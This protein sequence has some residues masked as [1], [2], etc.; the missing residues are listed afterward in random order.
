[1]PVS[2]RSQGLNPDG[3]QAEPP[4]TTP[5]SELITEVV[6]S[7][8]S[9]M[10]VTRIAPH[11]PCQSQQPI[12]QS[13][14]QYF[15]QIDPVFTNPTEDRT[16]SYNGEPN[17]LQAIQCVIND[18]C[19]ISRIVAPLSVP[20]AM[21]GQRDIEHDLRCIVRAI[22]MVVV[23]F[24]L[25]ANCPC[26]PIF[27]L[28]EELLRLFLV[29][30]KVTAPQELLGIF[31]NEL[32][33]GQALRCLVQIAAEKMRMGSPEFKLGII[34]RVQDELAYHVQSDLTAAEDIITTIWIFLEKTNAEHITEV[35][36][37]VRPDHIERI[38]RF[39]PPCIPQHWIYPFYDPG[40][41]SCKSEQMPGRPSQNFSPSQPPSL[42]G[43]RERDESDGTEE[44]GR[45][46]LR[47]GPLVDVTDDL[48]CTF[49]ADDVLN[50]PG[51]DYLCDNNLLRVALHYTN[52]DILNRMASTNNAFANDEFE[53]SSYTSPAPI[54]SRLDEAI[55]KLAMRHGLQNVKISDE[56]LLLRAVFNSARCANGLQ[57][58]PESPINSFSC[59]VLEIHCA[60]T[61]A[62]MEEIYS[63][64]RR[65]WGYNG[66][67]DSVYSDNTSP[68]R[69]TEEG[70]SSSSSS[71]HSHSDS[72]HT[73]YG[74]SNSFNSNHFAP[75]HTPSHSSNMS[76]SGSNPHARRFRHSHG[77]TNS[78]YQQQSPTYAPGTSPRPS[79]LPF[80][81]ADGQL[82][83]PDLSGPQSVP[84][85]GQQH[86]Q[87]DR[88]AGRAGHVPA[89]S[90]EAEGQRGNAH[91]STTA[92]WRR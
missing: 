9:S 40:Y 38:N 88:M 7:Q 71:G 59:T 50:L 30:N 13:R 70:S 57:S 46:R 37:I 87:F 31:S 53:A 77:L 41:T 72:V 64:I 52:I 48:P 15:R 3:E 60:Q 21:T 51:I 32:R 44:P 19:Y 85:E 35:L 84:V 61:L 91:N 89:W 42:L 43:K 68:A 29:R 22:L 25:R 27:P 28:E 62:A 36:P 58:I 81:G 17:D 20:V 79:P 63:T 67:S 86:Q 47:S 8:S 10:A 74:S 6:S 14:F 33:L 82:R 34:T 78:S 56:L 76:P 2:T 92:Q 11:L 45:S 80:T 39:S 4:C 18:G 55:H 73:M 24:A 83:S 1:M 65:A 69:Y 54:S 12:C 26:G 16:A 5:T 23:T 75:E 90:L 66:S 49:S